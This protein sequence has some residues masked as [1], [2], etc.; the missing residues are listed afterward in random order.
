MTRISVS[1]DV[2]TLNSRWLESEIDR[3][4]SRHLHM[5]SWGQLSSPRF[6]GWMQ[7]QPP[8]RPWQQV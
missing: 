8:K 4:E 2:R 5:Q 1:P 3:H 6:P 7:Q